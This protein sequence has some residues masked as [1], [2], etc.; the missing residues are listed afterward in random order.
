MRVVADDVYRWSDDAIR[1]APIGVI[2]SSTAPLQVTTSELNQAPAF[3]ADAAR[4]AADTDGPSASEVQSSGFF[5]RMNKLIETH[6]DET[7]DYV[8]EAYDWMDFA[9][10]DSSPAEMRLFLRQKLSGGPDVPVDDIVD[11][12]TDQKDEADA[13]A[14]LTVWAACF[15]EG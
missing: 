15:D 4:I 9:S 12:V 2:R 6:G 1:V 14:G 3:L 10:E 7:M 5:E 13:V 8:C 11:S